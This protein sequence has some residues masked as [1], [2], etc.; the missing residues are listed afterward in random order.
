MKKASRPRGT[1][2]YGL[3]DP[4]TG[5]VRYIGKTTRV[6]TVRLSA[7]MSSTRRGGRTHRD[8][9]M[10]S[11]GAP[12]GI[13]PILVVEG[14]TGAEMEQRVIAMYRGRGARLT[15]LTDGGEG[16]PGIVRSAEWRAKLSVALRG[17]K[18]SPEMRAKLSAERRGR[19]ISPEHRAKMV[20]GL[21]GHYCSPETRAKIGAAHRGKPKLKLRGRV[22]SPEYRARISASHKG[23]ALSK[24]HCAAIG[25]A[26]VGKPLS[27]ECRAKISAALRGRPKGPMSPEHHAKLSANHRRYQSPET[28]EKISATRSAEMAA[29]KLASD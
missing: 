19:P 29:R 18:M 14:A 5:E 9:W 13:R 24:E 7:H 20:A 11:L 26:H 4:E 25:A 2:I 3:C 1:T 16:T 28:R 23:V 8:N 21:R 6:L 12:P 15:N 10:R 22:L 27:V 17:R